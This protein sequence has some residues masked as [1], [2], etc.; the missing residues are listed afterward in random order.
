MDSHKAAK[1][2]FDALEGWVTGT[3]KNK[4]YN[5]LKTTHGYTENQRALQESFAKV[6]SLNNWSNTDLRSWLDG[7]FDNSKY[8]C[9]YTEVAILAGYSHG[10][11]NGAGWGDGN[12]AENGPPNCGP[13]I[14]NLQVSRSGMVK[15]P[16]QHAY[17]T[18]NYYIGY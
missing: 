7:D 16:G 13:W 15:A 14:G 5:A 9:W 4:V 3:P 18:G 8:K 10:S 2:L 11:W 12:N 6:C 1:D 17:P